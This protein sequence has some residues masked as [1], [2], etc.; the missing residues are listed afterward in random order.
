MTPPPDPDD[1]DGR[2]ALVAE[3]VLGLLPSGEHERVGRLIEQSPALQAEHD[4]W[5]ARFGGLDDEFA[6]TAP[7]PHVRRAIEE[8]LFGNGARRASLWDSLALWRG[9]AA[10]AVAVAV[11]AVG[12]TLLQPAPD[13]QALANQL[14]AML[15][16][17][18]SDVRFVAFYDGS[19]NVRLTGL[20]GAAV[21]NRDYELWAI[22]GD[23]APVSMGVIPVNERS[24]VTL[25]PDILAD[26]QEGSVLAVTL[27][28]EGGAPQG[29]PT[30]PVVAKGAVTRI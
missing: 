30:G 2:Q 25:P 22:Q 6:E 12:F 13:A 26:W 20:S 18:G 27:E 28:P 24:A 29:I 17:E 8:R 11:A 7:P 19:G 14:V 10:G 9:I 1:R 4:M 23:E 16:E 15:E 3:Y 5:M 21:D